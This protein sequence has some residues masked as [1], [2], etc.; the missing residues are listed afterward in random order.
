MKKQSLDSYTLIFFPIVTI[1]LVG[2]LASFSS[3]Y[4]LSWSFD[5]QGIRP[6]VRDTVLQIEDSGFVSSGVVGIAGKR[7]QQWYRRNWLKRNAKEKELIKLLDYPDGAVKATVYESLLMRRTAKEG[8]ELLSKA[9]NDT[10][11]FFY[12]QSGCIGDVVMLGEYLVENCV[13]ISEEQPS[14][15]NTFLDLDDFSNEERD[16]LYQLY[17]KRKARKRDYIDQF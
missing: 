16:H 15:I 6:E 2:L 17:Q 5:W 13:R 8:V 10:T 1:V 12:F 11:T 3:A 14:P 7:P 4:R 9:L